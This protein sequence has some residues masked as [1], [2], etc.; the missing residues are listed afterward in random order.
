MCPSSE[1]DTQARAWQ[2]A[3]GAQPR[4]LCPQHPLSPPL[5]VDDLL[6]TQ[7]ERDRWSPDRSLRCFPRRPKFLEWGEPATLLLLVLLGLALGLVLAALGLFVR[8]RDS[9]LVQAS[10]GPRACFGLACLGLVCLSTL[11]YP[12]RPRPAHCLAR[13]LLLHLPLAGCLS[14]LVL[15]AAEVFVESELRPSRADRLRSHLQGPQAWLAVLLAMLVEAALCAWS[16]GAFPPEVVTDWQALPTEAL[17]HC[18]MRSWVAFG[19]PHSANA[20]LASLCFL[21]AFL[22]HGRPGRCG[23]ARGL[24]FAMLAYFITWVSFVP[25]FANVHVAHQPAV[26]MGASLLCALGILATVHLPT[27]CLLLRQPE[28]NTPEFFSGGVPGDAG[29]RGGSGAEQETE[30]QQVTRDPVALPR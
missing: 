11:L 18:R 23:G 19:L 6:C 14:T 15:Q 8:H 12:G 9:P 21:G 1:A 27:C 20:L 24:T 25:L 22:G 4:G 17:V 7:C 5:A 26:Q 13:Q 28:S 29:G 3:G 10:G 30:Q 16:L 2:G